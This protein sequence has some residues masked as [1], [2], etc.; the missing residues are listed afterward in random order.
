M[1]T[2][3]GLEALREPLQAETLHRGLG[4]AAGARVLGDGA[5]WQWRRADDGGGRPARGWT[6][7]TV[8]EHLAAVD[9]EARFGEDSVA[10]TAW[11]ELWKWQWKRELAVTI[12]R[13]WK[14]L[15]TE[16]EEGSFSGEPLGPGGG[17]SAGP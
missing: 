9:R 7:G 11:L 3:Q 4:Q 8:G 14:E 12:I 1:A 10:M 5:V 16:L 6:T 17:L 15:L 2:R 13:P